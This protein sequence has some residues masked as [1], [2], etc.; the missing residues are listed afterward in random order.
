MELVSKYDYF[1]AELCFYSQSV[2][3]LKKKN[4]NKQNVS[5]YVT[6]YI[7]PYEYI[8]SKMHMWLT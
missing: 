7:R 6:N 2:R 1:N 4:Y 3:D 5:H 8:R